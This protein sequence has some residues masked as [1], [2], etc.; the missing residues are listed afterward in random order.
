MVR[1][2]PVPGPVKGVENGSEHGAATDETLHLCREPLAECKREGACGFD[3]RLS[4]CPG[5]TTN[6]LVA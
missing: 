1:A 2:G 5:G 4:A 6:V 3:R